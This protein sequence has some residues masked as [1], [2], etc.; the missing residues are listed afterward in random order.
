MSDPTTDTRHHLERCLQTIADMDIDD[1]GYLEIDVRNARWLCDR[2]AE[3]R[4][5]EERL[6]DYLDAKRALEHRRVIEGGWRYMDG[7]TFTEEE[8]DRRLIVAA[9]AEVAARDVLRAAV[10]S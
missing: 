9:E 7:T 8:H 10:W 1:P 2:L 4:Q 6:R 5:V 3:L